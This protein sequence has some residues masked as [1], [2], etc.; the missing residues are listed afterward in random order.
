MPQPQPQQ[1]G[2]PP[3]APAPPCLLH[4]KLATFK[5]EYPLTLGNMLK[6]DGFSY[7]I[8]IPIDV[9]PATLVAEI[10]KGAIQCS[11]TSPVTP[12]R[13]GMLN[14]IVGTRLEPTLDAFLSQP[15]PTLHPGNPWAVTTWA[16]QKSTSPPRVKTGQFVYI[17]PPVGDGIIN[18]PV[19][20]GDGIIRSTLELKPCE[21]G[22]VSLSSGLCHTV[23]DERALWIGLL[24]AH[25]QQKGC[26]YLATGFHPVGA[27]GAEEAVPICAAHRKKLAKHAADLAMSPS[28]AA[29]NPLKRRL[30]DQHP[31][32][33]ARS[34][35]GVDGPRML[36]IHLKTAQGL[37]EDKKD[38]LV[39][40]L[41][42]LQDKKLTGDVIAP[43]IT[44]Q[45]SISGDVMFDVKINIDWTMPQHEA[46]SG[47][48][49]RGK[50]NAWVDTIKDIIGADNVSVW[51]AYIGSLHL[52]LSCSIEGYERLLGAF[53][54]PGIAMGG[55][56][57]V[58]VDPIICVSLKGLASSVEH[59][60]NELK[61]GCPSNDVGVAS[62][63]GGQPLLKL[64]CGCDG[65]ESAHTPLKGAF[66][67][68]DSAQDSAVIPVQTVHQRAEPLAAAVKAQTAQPHAA[69][70]SVPP[71]CSASSSST[72][73]KEAGG[74]RS[75]F[76]VLPTHPSTAGDRLVLSPRHRSVSMSGTAG[77]VATTATR[78]RTSSFPRSS[79]PLA[80]ARQLPRTV[81]QQH[82][83]VVCCLSGFQTVSQRRFRRHST[84]G[85]RGLR[86]GGRHRPASP[87]PF[88]QP[89]SP[90]VSAILAPLG[91]ARARLLMAFSKFRLSPSPFAADANLEA[92]E[93]DQTEILA[94]GGTSGTQADVS[95][96]EADDR[97]INTPEQ[98]NEFNDVLIVGDGC[99]GPHDAIGGNN[100]SDATHTYTPPQVKFVAAAPPI[101]HDVA[102]PIVAL[103]RPGARGS[104]FFPSHRPMSP[105]KFLR[106]PR[107]P[108]NN[109]KTTV[110]YLP[111]ASIGMPV[112][113]SGPASGRF[114]SGR[115]VI[116]P[117]PHRRSARAPVAPD[118]ARQG[119][120]TSSTRPSAAMKQ[121]KR[122]LDEFCDELAEINRVKNIALPL[123]IRT[124]STNDK[125]I[126]DE[127]DAVG[128][129]NSGDAKQTTTPPQF[130]WFKPPVSFA[131]AIARPNVA[132]DHPEN[133]ERS[134]FSPS[135]RP[136]SR[137]S[138]RV[139]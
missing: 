134:A 67:F 99:R 15:P 108:K 88:H 52:V 60:A 51:R 87:I 75:A 53:R 25:G 122:E 112:T 59:L 127:F 30:A 130:G 12:R 106:D 135:H 1:L 82:E 31:D 39:A 80:G 104:A 100:L 26:A 13:R 69:S 16:E 3:T 84:G 29:V 46:L 105:K 66:S 121:L 109:R 17:N 35:E 10:K 92:I 113:V 78:R 116:D 129:N 43:V 47:P 118:V 21:D 6:T 131:N 14:T 34:G 49:E 117:R 102:R 11:A 70:A 23:L 63:V 123:Q 72:S 73:D 28:D 5:H 48:D 4:V 57:I 9:T 101:A 138:H 58:A 91:S 89:A 2:R 18:P 133:R 56:S 36:L 41:Q 24:C 64:L 125:R 98:G 132:P 110:K 32:G 54:G 33:P 83:N 96:S 114:H 68:F 22:G 124:V 97:D 40:T 44:E 45:E 103:G 50:I 111:R 95:Y 27:G 38:D 139:S 77:W 93:A 7:D 79:S 107:S 137:S 81:M 90:A 37:L 119:V 71:T 20:G 62:A 120:L 65:V 85:F 86:A 42:D 126:R 136:M 128:G 76:T 74:R 61:M 8:N 115:G 55:D 19:G 94:I